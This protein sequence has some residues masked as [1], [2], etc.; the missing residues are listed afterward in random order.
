MLK[1]FFELL[2]E[3]KRRWPG[4]GN[5]ERAGFFA[6]INDEASARKIRDFLEN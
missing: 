4:I 5:E 3:L 1:R 2:D 6:S